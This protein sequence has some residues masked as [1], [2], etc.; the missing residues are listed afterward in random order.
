M[1][2]SRRLWL[3]GLVASLGVVGVVAVA[4]GFR[5]YASAVFKPAETVSRTR[6]SIGVP[7]GVV[8]NEVAWMGTEADASDEWI[9][10][11]NAASVSASLEGWRLVDDDSLV[12]TLTGEI[13]PHGYYLIER[14]DDNA[15]TDV[16]ADWYGS[17]GAGGLLNAG[18][19]LTLT[20]DSGT[21]VDTANVDGGSWPAGAASSGTPR[22]ATMERVD[23]LAG[24]EAVTK[25][26]RES[27]RL[28]GEQ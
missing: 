12:I 20:D 26:F 11:F 19:V 1:V 4:A 22:Y 23:P 27:G 6:K 3:T 16:P 18:Q 2:H 7:R 28:A 25:A 24:D 8:I 10:L 21:L 9:E 5:A 13:P 14:T 15:V 17:F